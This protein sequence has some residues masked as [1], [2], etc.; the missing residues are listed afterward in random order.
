MLTMRIEARYAFRALLAR[1]G[2]TALIVLSL[3]L[4]LGANATIFAMVDA[5]VI[6][7]FPFPGVDRVAFVAG[8][9][10]TTEFKQESVSPADFLDWRAQAGTFQNLVAMQWWDVSVLGTDEPESVQGFLVSP[11]F[12]RA[13]GVQPAIGRGFLPEEEV[14]GRHRRAV[15]GQGVWQRRF[16]G[17]PALVGK[18]V[19]LD[20]EPYEVVGIAPLGFDFP[21][22]TEVWAPLAFTPEQST[23]RARRFLSVI[24]RLRDGSR[25]ADARAEMSVIGERLRQR[26]PESNKDRGVRVMTLQNGMLDEGLGPV[27]SLWQASAAFVL[28]IACANIASLL[29]AQG[30]ERHRDI[31]IRLAMGAGRARIV[32]EL[33]LESAMLGLLA[34]PGAMLAAWGGL[35]VLRGAMPA[36]IIRFLPG[37][38]ALTIDM[39]SLAATSALAVVAAALFGLVPALQAARPQLLDALK[40]GGRSATAGRGRHRLRRALVVAE[41]AL[42]V[43]LL[44][45][46]ALGANGAYRFLNGPQGYDPDGVLSMHAVLP[47]AR[48]ADPGARR[49]FTQAVVDRLQKIPGV[50]TAAAINVRPSHP[51]NVTRAVDIDGQP[52]NDPARRPEVDFRAATGDLFDVLRIPILQGR[53]FTPGDRE[54][55]QPIAVVNLS[56]ARRYWS[57]VDP[58]GQRLRVGSGP[59]LTV[60]GVCGDVIQDWFLNRSRAAVYVP[61]SQDPTSNVALLVRTSGDP[62]TLA[63]QAR[64]AVRAVDA[65]QPVFDVMTMREALKERTVG[66]R[67]IAGVMAVFGGLALLLAIVGTYSVMAFFVTQRTHEIGIRIALGATPGDVL[68]LTVTQSGKLTAIGVLLGI[69]LSVLL[70]RLIEAGLVGAATSDGRMIALVAGILAVAALAAGYIPARR[71]AAIDPIAALRE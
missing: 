21:N 67:F 31:A 39:R 1:P 59:W 3:A 13:L 52:T 6:H 68:R 12:F 15:L 35:D 65:S 29:L 55:S 58:I 45:A 22:G 48:Y 28:L 9:S 14:P 47:A 26:Y 17:D 24:G 37:W 71:A 20:R 61:Y 30:A 54:D 69:G 18:T 40:E 60:I 66:L 33:L 62:A 50:E 57:G 8:R 25:L 53:G 4:G 7:P 51:G 19:T 56:L 44:V 10:P 41:I 43:P 49:N 63:S 11:D 70:A 16:G 32:R 27:L 64:A 23:N 2:I 38:N 36:K 34:V 42:A 5:L 46:S